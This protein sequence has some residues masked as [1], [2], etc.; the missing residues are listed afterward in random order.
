MAGGKIDI[1]VE[2]DVKGFGPKMESG[3]S[4][5]LGMAGKIGASLGLALGGAAAVKSVAELGIAFD[6]QMNTL[7]AVSQATGAQLEAVAQRARDLGKSSDLTATSASDAAAAMTELVKGGFSVE[8]AMDAAKGTLQ[9]ASAAQIEAAEAA[10]IQSQALQAFGLDATYAATASD[11]LAG[12]ANASSADIRG[13]ANGLQQSGAVANQ[14]GLTLEDNA[15]A[16]AMFANAGIQGS[17]AG[18][19]LKTALL[20]M[21]KDS[22]AAREAMDDLGLSVYTAEGTFV[23]MEALFGQLADAQKRMTDEQYQHAT[24]ALFGSDAM[25]MAGIAAR[26]GSEGWRETYEAVTRAGQASE[27]AAAQAQGLPGVLEAIGNQAE[28][29]GIAVYEAFSGLALGGGQALVAGIEKIGPVIELTAQQVAGLAEAT[30]PAVGAVANLGAGLSGL[31]GPIGGIA[32]ALALDHFTGFSKKA[33]A[34][35]SAVKALGT[36]A[37]ANQRF[38]SSMGRE[39]SVATGAL[40]ALEE[41]SPVLNRMGDAYRETG[42]SLRVAGAMTR[43][44]S[45]ETQGLHQQ[46]LLAKGSMETFGGVAQGVAA[47]GVSALKSGVSGLIGFLGGPWG[48]AF[49]A[50]GLAVGYLVQQHQA[51]ALAEAEHEAAQK[52]LRDTLDSTT[53]AVSEQTRALQEKTLQESG[54]LDTARE[55]G[56]AASTVV[57]AAMGNAAAQREVAAAVEASTLK[58]I[59]GSDAWE[60]HRDAFEE[61]GLGAEDLTAAL[62][63]NSE[64]AGGI[65]RA[66]LQKTFNEIRHEIKDTTEAAND[67]SEGVLG[68]ADALNE[69]ETT[70]AKTQL[71]ELEKQAKQTTDVVKAIGDAQFKIRDSQTV[72]LEPGAINEETLAQLEEVHGITSEVMNGEL[73]LTFENGA[74]VLG[75]LEEIGVTLEKTPEGYIRVN[76][77]DPVRA[78][79]ILEGMGLQLREIEGDPTRLEIDSNVPEVL[80]Q[81]EKYGLAK[82]DAKGELVIDWSSITTSQEKMEQLKK[83]VEAGA[84]GRA[85]IEENSREVW[86][87]IRRNLDGKVTYGKHVVTAE[88]AAVMHS[89][90]VM[91]GG[92]GRTVPYAD[93]AVRAAADGWLSDQ[94]AQIARGGSWLVWAEDETEGESFIPHAPSKRGRAVQIMAETAKLFGL[95]LVD[96]GGNQVKRDGTSVAPTGR[97]FADGAVRTAEEILAFADGKNVAGQQ[98][99]RSLEGA[100]Y[101][102][103]GSNWGD[104]SSTQ[105]QLALFA[106]GKPATGGRYMATM[107]ADQQ[108]AALGWQTGLG[109]PG[110]F[111]IGWLNGGPGGGHASGTVAGVNVE[112][113]GGR[114]NGQIGGGAAPAS[115]PQYTHHRHIPLSGEG[116]ITSTSTSGYTRASARGP[117]QV[118]WGSAQDIHDR[119]AKA[120]RIYDRGG[121]LP[122]GGMAL[123]LGAPERVLPADLTRSFDRFVVMV[124]ALLAA[125]NSATGGTVS[126]GAVDSRGWGELT[127][128]MGAAHSE[129][130]A[131][132]MTLGGDFL[133]TTELVRDAEKGLRDTRKAIRQESIDLIEQEEAV[134]QARRDLAKL[135][136]GGGEQSLSVSRRLEDAERR[137]SEAREAAGE[138][139]GKT[140]RNAEARASAMQSANEKVE[141]AERALMRAREDAAI[142][143]EK[144]ADKH[145]KDLVKARK[146][147]EAA[148]ADL[149]DMREHSLTAAQRLEAAERTVAAARAEAAARLVST[150]G[151]A[152]AS[153]A[154]SVASFYQA[155]TAAA[156]SMEQTRQ[157]LAAE[158]LELGRLTLARRRAGLDAI[159]AEQDLA[160]AK[161][162]GAINIADAEAELAGIRRESVEQGAA[163]TMAGAT[164]VDAMSKAVDRF[165]VSGVFAVERVAQAQQSSA[166][167]SAGAMVSYAN[168]VAVAEHNVAAVRAQAALDELDAAHRHKMALLDVAEATL[169]Q[170]HAV[171]LVKI[172]TEQL[173]AQARA[174]GDLTEAQAAGAAEGW[175][176]AA[177]GASG[178]GKLLVGGIKAF[179]GF[180]TGGGGLT[181]LIQGL[182]AGGLE[183][184]QGIFDL[185]SGI[186]DLINNWDDVVAAFQN[187]DL[188]EQIVTALSLLFGFATPGAVAA[189]GG[190]AEDVAKATE[191]GVTAVEKTAQ[192]RQ[193]SIEKA[194][195]RANRKAEADRAAAEREHQAQLAAIDAKRHGLEMDYA[196]ESVALQAEITI[197]ELQK[198]IAAASTVEQATAL[199]AA[200]EVAAERRDQMLDVLGRQLDLAEKQAAA[201]K[202][203]VTINVPPGVEYV[204]RVEFEQ[205]VKAFM[206]M[207]SQVDVK[208]T[209]VSG[210]AYVSART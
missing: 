47:G 139:A 79:E 127:I 205:V 121:I 152:L 207:Q 99:S 153:V 29:T 106:M 9:L 10:T 120:L 156:A 49:T 107:N 45:M 131:F 180:L 44:A 54:A 94:E 171:K 11:I 71:L 112:M 124:P 175:G 135:E 208:S 87:N 109:G 105:G 43:A 72:S 68:A 82:K 86:D 144:Q 1:L 126:G 167:S 12:A 200:A 61:A 210:A 55:F 110:D 78:R 81:L 59:E 52:A 18:T 118:N 146:Q 35:A 60:K 198:S 31:S 33:S 123:N 187:M 67:L 3:L 21:T 202:P 182:L 23:G 191:I 150:V 88:T 143:A 98:A 134:A 66:G 84:K 125:L 111:S 189:G 114:G 14:F 159:I 76:A 197:A 194:V 181:G 158:R 13:I 22:K 75:L 204:P 38:F 119:A 184:V 40:V 129:A 188:G 166:A 53:G 8:A 101:V 193:E 133:G 90:A 157:Q 185:I 51:A 37:K 203:S 95:G 100:P 169:A 137:L 170:D 91:S 26:E 30:L 89:S 151:N 39:I 172:S 48:A 117:I 103:G 195:E 4:G 17:D 46:M 97:A 142:D 162:Q 27:V 25:R 41:R 201:P 70:N 192:F 174:L 65:L 209:S 64:A 179:G 57:D 63:G 164:G 83:L 116:T 93:G 168:Q 161:A 34:G 5:A 73:I 206:E 155:M 20:S 74:D 15:T 190:N 7:S 148:E 58:A 85:E 32:A 96:A 196:A 154:G 50:A 128:Q 136:A 62:N 42:Q 149:A 147:L 102:Y 108:L 178:L 186:R 138:T 130:K 177:Q 183:I 173:E 113:G 36:E 77:D 16:L 6:E 104:C 2:P 160:A 176:G 132:A 24:A 141:D 80:V 165:R 56:I 140:H 19:L 145:S 69:A 163:A 122:T 92:R 199:Q 115:H 28:D